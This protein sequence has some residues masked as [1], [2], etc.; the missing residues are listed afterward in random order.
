MTLQYTAV[1]IQN[2]SHMAVTIDDYWTD[3]ENLAGSIGYCGLELQPRSAGA[4]GLG[5]RR[6]HRR[7]VPGRG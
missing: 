7:L 6:R 2:E 1:G 3:L 5:V 4:A